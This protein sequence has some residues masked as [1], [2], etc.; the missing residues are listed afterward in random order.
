MVVWPLEVAETAT[1]LSPVP[2]HMHLLDGCS[3]DLPPLNCVG[4]ELSFS[5]EIACSNFWYLLEGDDINFV[6]FE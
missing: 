1:K 4:S 2:L 3:I 5:R 6:T